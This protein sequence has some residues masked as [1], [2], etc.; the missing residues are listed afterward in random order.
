VHPAGLVLLSVAAALCLGR[1]LQAYSYF[2]F[3]LGLYLI[4]DAYSI[5]TY[6][7]TSDPA[8]STLVYLAPAVALLLTVPAVHFENRWFRW[9]WAIVAFV[10]AGAWL[11]FAMTTTPSHLHP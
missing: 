11:Y 6:K 4:S 1:G 10:F 8:K 5:F 7:L 2:G 3:I 9:L